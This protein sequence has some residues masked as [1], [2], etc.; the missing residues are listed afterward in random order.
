[1]DMS[2]FYP[3]S[4]YAMNIDPSTLLFK[5]ICDPNQFNNM[6]G[7]LKYRGITDYSKVDATTAFQLGDVSKEIIDNFQTGDVVNTM[8]KWFNA[9]SIDDLLD[10]MEIDNSYYEGGEI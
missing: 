1:M 10:E 8:T 4:I 5:C 6:G 7:R 9:P 2:S 3:S